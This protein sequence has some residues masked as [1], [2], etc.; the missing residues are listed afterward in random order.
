MSKNTAI[1]PL[2][3]KKLLNQNS[4]INGETVAAHEKLE[5]ELEKLGVEIRPRFNVE[6]PLGSNRTGC[7]S[8]NT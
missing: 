5:Q 2:D 7:Y 4:N 8:R 1:S 6:P 3:R